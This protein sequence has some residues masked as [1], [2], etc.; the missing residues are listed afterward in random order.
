MLKGK[1]S[2]TI[3]LDALIRLLGV[4]LVILLIILP[5]YDNIHAAIVRNEALKSFSYFIEQINK[6]PLRSEKFILRLNDKSAIIGFSK[7]SDKYECFN[8]YS[9]VQNPRA[10]VIFSKPKDN[11]CDNSACICLCFDGFQIMEENLEGKPKLGQCTTN[12]DC[13]KVENADIVDK[14]IVKFYPGLNVGF[15]ILGGGAEYWKN[16]F[17]FVNGVS[18]ANRLKLY[19]EKLTE[20]IVERRSNLIGVCNKEIMELNRNELKF[21]SCIINEYDEAK[22]LESSNPEEALK[23]YKEFVNKYK[24]GLEVQESLFITGKTYFVQGNYQESAEA[25][26]QLTNEFPTTNYKKEATEMLTK[27]DKS[28]VGIKAC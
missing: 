20:L 24:K 10:T 7:N 6:M 22:K 4:V 16:G 11:A 15:T 1:K 8:C 3:S 27:I 14:T 19:N 13:R 2:I 25:L 26:C 28:T 23:K 21:N 5:T 12:L 18:G 17:L 9:G